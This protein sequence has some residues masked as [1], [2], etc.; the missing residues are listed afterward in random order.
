MQSYSNFTQEDLDKEVA[1]T[2]QNKHRLSNNQNLIKWYQLLYEQI[3]K[4]NPKITPASRILEIG[5]GT[6][7]LRLFV[8]TVIT[9]DVLPID[10]LDYTFD[11][12]QIDKLSEIADGSLDVITMTNVLH[13]LEYP[14]EALRKASCK[15]RSGGIVI[16]VEP[17]FS[18]V[19][20]L[21]YLF[22]HHEPTDFSAKAPII[23]RKNGPL[24]TAN[25][26]MPYLIFFKKKKWLDALSDIY[27]TDHL[28]FSFFSSLSYALT[29]GIANKLSIPRWLFNVI[30][31]ADRLLARTFPKIFSFEFIVTI[32][33]K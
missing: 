30:L 33:K 17:Y 32:E 2:L 9:S 5:S 20:S 3:F 7:P 11:I 24:E 12:H 22:L 8:P 1:V 28:K 23:E 6:S 31:P 13:H 16:C 21:I 15:L 14:V 19:S 26:C 29:G 25:I 10:H 18:W 4:N 27:Q